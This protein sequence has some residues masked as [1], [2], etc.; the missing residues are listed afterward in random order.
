MLTSE[1]IRTETFAIMG[2]TSI[3]LWL[4]S[5]LLDLGR[6]FSF[7]IF[8]TVVRTPWTGD[9]SVVRPLRIHRTIQTQNKRTQT[10]MSQVVFELTIPVFEWAKTVHALETFPRY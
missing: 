7:L 2:Q 4:Y 10:F 5:P 1:G 9:Q 8:Y 6:I 3:Y